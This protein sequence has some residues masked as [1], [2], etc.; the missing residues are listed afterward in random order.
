MVLRGTCASLRKS[1]GSCCRSRPPAMRSWSQSGVKAGVA[2]EQAPLD[3]EGIRKVGTAWPAWGHRSGGGFDYIPL[4][5]P[6][7]ALALPVSPAIAA[8]R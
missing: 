4:S 2:Q 3:A 1:C 5:S 6:P 7:A 8:T